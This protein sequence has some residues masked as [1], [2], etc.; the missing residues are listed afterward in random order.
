MLRPVIIVYIL[1][2]P[3]AIVLL[4]G[5]LFILSPPWHEPERAVWGKCVALVGTVCVAGL[6]PLP[7][8]IGLIFT[9]VLTLLGMNLLFYKSIGMAFFAFICYSVLLWLSLWGIGWGIGHLVF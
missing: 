7:S 9:K 4:R 6:L 3:A 8:P 1:Y 5:T 2:V